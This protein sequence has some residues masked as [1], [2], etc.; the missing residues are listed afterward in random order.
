MEQ[1]SASFW[2]RFNFNDADPAE[3]SELDE[4]QALNLYDYIEPE[5]NAEEF[6]ANRVDGVRPP[7]V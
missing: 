4:G 2:L 5:M 3:Y 6:H 7:S 1:T